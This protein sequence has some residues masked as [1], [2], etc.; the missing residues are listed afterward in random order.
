MAATLTPWLHQEVKD[1]LLLGHSWLAQ[2]NTAKAALAKPSAA[3]DQTWAGLYHD[4]GSCLDII[5]PF[6][7]EQ[8]H[9]LVVRVSRP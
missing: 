7:S 1:Q 5:V 4:N 2:K 8:A 9:V 3:V 6:V